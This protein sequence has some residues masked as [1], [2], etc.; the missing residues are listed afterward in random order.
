MA[1]D[2]PD[3]E[4]DAGSASGEL[5]ARHGGR[6]HARTGSHGGCEHRSGRVLLHVTCSFRAG[7]GTW[8]ERYGTRQIHATGTYASPVS[9]LPLDA[10]RT[11]ALRRAADH[12]EQAWAS[13][14]HARDG[15]P[16]L[17]DV[18][19]R[20]LAGGLPEDA[21]PVLEALDDAAQVLDE[22]LAPARPRYFAFVGSSGLEVAVLA[23]ALASASTSTSPPTRA[24]PTASSARRCDWVGRFVGYPG[25]G[26][27]V[28][29][30]RHDLEPDG[31]RGGARARAA[32][33]SGDRS[34]RP[35][36]RPLLLGR[37]ALQRRSGRPRC[38]GIGA[39][40]VRSIPIDDR[41][42]MIAAEAAA[43]IDADVA[44][45]IT[46]VAVVATAGTTLTGAVDPIGELA[47]IC[48]ER[49]V[50]LHVDGAYGLPAAAGTGHGRAVRR[51][52][53][54]RLRV[55]RRA[56]VAVPAEGLR[57]GAGARPRR[58]GARVR[59]RRG[60]HAALGRRPE[61]RRPHARVLAA[62]PGAQALA[63]VPGARR[64]GVP[65]GDRRNIVLARRLAE[66]IRAHPELRAG[67]GR[68]AALDRAVP[69]RAAGRRRPRRAQPGAGRG[70]AERLARLRLVGGDRRPRVPAAVHRQLPHHGG[71]RAGARRRRGRARPLAVATT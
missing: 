51:A 43:A 42:R 61:R 68:A 65:R 28:H 26:R 2:G 34:R 9:G 25:H 4:A 20:V 59:A 57:R 12:I 45:G 13:F 6:A 22:S 29:Q 48:A 39:G 30:R 55:G 37:G 46:P 16:A 54:G 38:S 69:A 47:G 60:V 49:G 8:V 52:R 14:D 5:Q 27:R 50:W 32:R 17:G 67:R 1:L 3:E 70:A 44:A 15:Q 71:G 11:A 63:R 24:W 58:A 62:V 53:P 21:T 66:I 23:D 7:V 56:Q 31:A 64:G 18:L 33:R 40:N 35:G 10:P 36:R 41:R 19:G